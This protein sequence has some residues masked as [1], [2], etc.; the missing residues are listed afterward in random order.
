MESHGFY[1]VNIYLFNYVFIFSTWDR[2][3]ECSLD[4]TM[5]TKWEIFLLGIS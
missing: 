4:P 1:F 5:S 2:N 3:N